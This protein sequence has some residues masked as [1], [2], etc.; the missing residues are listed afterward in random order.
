MRGKLKLYRFKAHFN[1]INMWSR[2]DPNF[3]K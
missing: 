2:L 1:K 3:N